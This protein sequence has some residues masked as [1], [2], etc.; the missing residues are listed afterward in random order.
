[1]LIT[2]IDESLSDNFLDQKKKTNKQFSFEK[3]K[4]NPDSSCFSFCGGSTRTR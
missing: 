1:M 4:N 3:Q 2:A